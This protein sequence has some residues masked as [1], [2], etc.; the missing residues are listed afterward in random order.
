MLS[1]KI[2]GT[3]VTVV[4][5]WLF[6]SCI[7]LAFVVSGEPAAIGHIY[8]SLALSALIIVTSLVVKKAMEWAEFI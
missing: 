7:M 6:I 5:F 1:S 3:V 2:V 4:I 8:T